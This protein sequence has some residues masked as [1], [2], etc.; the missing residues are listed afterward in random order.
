MFYTSLSC[1]GASVEAERSGVGVKQEDLLSVHVF[2]ATRL[3]FSSVR[4]HP[5]A[6]SMGLIQRVVGTQGHC[7]PPPTEGVVG[8]G[9]SFDQ[10][11][12]L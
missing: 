12:P 5:G 9:S 1:R 10:F 8:S 6:F 11:R 7:Q 4:A 2:P 3:C